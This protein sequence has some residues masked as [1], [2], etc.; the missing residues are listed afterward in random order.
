MTTCDIS[1]ELR[2]MA[3]S[4]P[5]NENVLLPATKPSKWNDTEVFERVNAREFLNF[6]ADMFE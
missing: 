6:L 1:Q 3:D 5:E 4:K 2:T